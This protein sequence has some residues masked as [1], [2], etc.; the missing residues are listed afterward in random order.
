MM[1][2]LDGKGILHYYLDVNLIKPYDTH[3]LFPSRDLILL[4]C[5]CLELCNNA[6]LGSR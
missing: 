5:I 6:G 1:L 4:D 3:Q 2:Y